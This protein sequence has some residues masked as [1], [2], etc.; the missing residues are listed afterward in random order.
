MTIHEL[1]CWTPSFQALLD[2]TKTFEL[3]KN[4][5]DFKLSDV[6][7]LREWNPYRKKDGTPSKRG[8]YSGRRLKMGV[9]WTLYEGFGLPAGYCIM[10]VFP[11]G[12]TP[13]RPK[14]VEKL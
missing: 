10:S 13:L 6:L 4:D 1:R 7:D 14:D 8:K 9:G 2:G 3:R 12:W 5:R 11:I